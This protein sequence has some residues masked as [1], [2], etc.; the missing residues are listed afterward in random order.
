MDKAVKDTEN[1]I[2]LSNGLAAP[3]RYVSKCGRADCI[4]CK[5]A[6]GYNGTVWAGRACQWGAQTMALANNPWRNIAMFYY[7]GTGW[8]FSDDVVEPPVPTP[9]DLTAE[10]NM[11]TCLTQ[12]VEQQRQEALIGF[13]ETL[14]ELEKIKTS[15]VAKQ[16]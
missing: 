15:L 5:G 2:L 8:K 10:I 14:G 7:G 11:V 6:N 12:E 1:I 16:Q 3:T 4:Y 9:I 13:N